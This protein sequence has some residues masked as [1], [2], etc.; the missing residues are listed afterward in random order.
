MSSADRLNRILG[1]IPYLLQHQDVS[2]M[3]LSDEFQVRPAELLRD[4][5]A[6]S[7]CSYG[8]F[9]SAEVMDAYIEEDRVHIW[10]GE[11]F[12]RPLSF[13][14]GE[15]MALRTAVSLMLEHTD[16]KETKAL[17][18]AHRTI[19]GV[20]D[21]RDVWADAFKGKIGVDSSPALSAEIFSTFERGVHENRKVRIR[22]F[23]E[24]RKSIS[25]RVI[26]PYKMVNSDGQWYVVGFCE[27]A[28]GIR[29][30][31]VDHVRSAELGGEHFEVPGDF[32]LEDHFVHGVYVETETEEKIVI[33][34]LPPAARLVVE[35]E[36]RGRVGKD[37]SVILPYHTSSPRWLL[38]R[39]LSYGEAAEIIEPLQFR[40]SLVELLAGMA[41]SYKE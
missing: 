1:M 41:E 8:P 15:L 3:E 33:R 27:R 16:A 34:Y 31:R 37:G 32:R 39:V 21:G 5:Q 14:P 20:Q 26:A 40:H 24:Q 10:A 35:E 11:H 30:F 12:K 4:L 29:T 19:T 17:A 7:N 28:D 18:R 13:T 38:Q 22:Y 25:E 23:T 2:L 9:G 6:L 36:G